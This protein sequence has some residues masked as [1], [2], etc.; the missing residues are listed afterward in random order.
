MRN[1]S[2]TIKEGEHTGKTLWSGRYC[3]VAAFTFCKIK[4]V[5]CVLANQRGSGTPDFQGYWNC[6]C[7]YLD[8]EKAEIACSRETFEETG[9]K[10]NPDRWTLF[11]VE[12]DPKNDS[13][14]NVTLRYIAILEY[15]KD[16]ISVSM[17]DVLNGGGEKNE[18][19]K[20]QW[21]PIRDIEKYEWAFNHK[22]RITEAISWYNIKVIE[23]EPLENQI[24][25]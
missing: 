12:T 21:I 20:I 2:Y 1:W 6:P 25:P 4:D 8:M 11:G 22:Q 17:E 16:D 15:G 9:V 13:N 14:G 10:I 19:E 24:V 3:A 18:V 7:G 23:S 5:W